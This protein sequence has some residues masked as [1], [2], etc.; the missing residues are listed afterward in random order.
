MSAEH[1]GTNDLFSFCYE[2]NCDTHTP[3]FMLILSPSM[4]CGCVWNGAWSRYSMVVECVL[5]RTG[6]G[7]R[8]QRQKQIRKKMGRKDGGTKGGARAFKQLVDL[9]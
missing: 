5:V 7:L 3:N 6:P 4:P 8:P 2:P 1:P 9:K